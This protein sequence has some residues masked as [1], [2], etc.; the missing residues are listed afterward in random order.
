MKIRLSLALAVASAFLAGTTGAFA[1]AHLK[2][3]MPASGSTVHQSPA[4][5]ELDFSEGL[6]IAFSGV[7]L[8]SAKGEKVTVG[9]AHLKASDDTTLIVPLPRPL[10][11]GHYTVSWHAL[12]RDGHKT[13]GSYAFAVAPK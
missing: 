7:T 5:L 8:K 1:H 6:N 11:A 2:T 10:A 9:K 4:E 12:S 3:A 13:K